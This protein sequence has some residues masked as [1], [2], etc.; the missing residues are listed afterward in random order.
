MTYG[1]QDQPKS[2]MRRCKSGGTNE[3]PSIDVSESRSVAAWVRTKSDVGEARASALVK[4]GIEKTKCGLTFRN[5][6]A[7]NQRDYTRHCLD[8]GSQLGA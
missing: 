4:P 5:K 2:K 7:I 1:T 3:I 8:I 6:E